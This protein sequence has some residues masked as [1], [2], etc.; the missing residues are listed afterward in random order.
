MSALSGVYVRFGGWVTLAWPPFLL[1]LPSISSAAPHEIRSP[2]HDLSSAWS[3]GPHYLRPGS[4]L[5][6]QLHKISHGLGA[7]LVAVESRNRRTFT[8]PTAPNPLSLNPRNGPLGRRINGRMEVAFFGFNVSDPK[9]GVSVKH[10][11]L[12]NPS[13]SQPGYSKG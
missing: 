3:A 6:T 2:V 7:Q 4:R 8:W 5:S 9:N 13:P 12:K 1:T 11:F 10:S